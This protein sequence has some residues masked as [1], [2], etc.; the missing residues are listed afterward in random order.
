[1]EPIRYKY[2]EYIINNNENLLSLNYSLHY[3]SADWWCEGF[4]HGH[5]PQSPVFESRPLRQAEW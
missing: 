1:M 5:G 4:Q 3:H 2:S